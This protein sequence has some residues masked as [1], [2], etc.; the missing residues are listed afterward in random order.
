MLARYVLPT[1]ARPA[2]RSILD[3][4]PGPRNLD[5]VDSGVALGRSVRLS[6]VV[7]VLGTRFGGPAPG[8]AKVVGTTAKPSP[9]LCS[10]N[11][12]AINKLVAAVLKFSPQTNRPQRRSTRKNGN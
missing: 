7:H 3:K 4:L 1:V 5:S 8:F 11:R 9:Q 12:E 10:A 6:S 2:L